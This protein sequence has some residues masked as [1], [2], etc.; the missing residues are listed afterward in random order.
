[1][2]IS[3]QENHQS[4]VHLFDSHSEQKLRV[5][6]LIENN[7]TSEYIL[8]EFSSRI[9]L[10]SKQKLRVSQLIENNMTSEY[11]LGEF[12][13]RILLTSEEK[14]TVGQRIENS[15]TN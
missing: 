8:G 1:M 5:S 13:S 11:I 3:N 9:L 4:S 15:L 14:L 6:Q 10:T 2:N 12:S 7:M